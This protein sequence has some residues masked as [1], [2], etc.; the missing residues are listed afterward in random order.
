[1]Y[2]KKTKIQNLI[3]ST[4]LIFMIIILSVGGI[5][6]GILYFSELRY[7]PYKQKIVNISARSEPYTLPLTFCE[8]NIIK[9]YEIPC[10]RNTIPYNVT[11]SPL[12]DSSHIAVIEAVDKETFDD[13]I[14]DFIS[15]KSRVGT[16]KAYITEDCKYVP[17]EAGNEVDDK[18]L[19]EAVLCGF[20]DKNTYNIKDYYFPAEDPEAEHKEELVKK[21][22][23]SQITYTDGSVIK[24]ID[25]DPSY[26]AIT[27]SISLNKARIRESA[28][29]V[30]LKYDTVGKIELPFD[31]TLRGN[32][33]ISGGTWGTLSDSLAEMDAAEK[34]LTNLEVSE[35]RIPILKQSQ[36]SSLPTTYIEVDKENQKVFVYENGVRIME[37]DCVTGR[38][39][40]RETP[41]GIYFISERMID[42]TLKGPGYSSFVKRWM[43]L[44]NSGVG[45]HDASWRNKFGGDI[46][47]RDGS[48]GCINLPKDFAYKLYDWTKEHNKTCVIIF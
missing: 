24:A 31:S 16:K 38:Y 23:A 33:M 18:K 36:P 13:N 45:L 4:I 48:H 47:L 22:A 40:D 46:Y 39:P 42:K 6:W 7:D 8:G 17:P 30:S 10:I 9:T 14:A 44:T 1:M 11:I 37:S 21:L 29:D 34:L 35:N 3:L 15:L 2:V 12:Y 43:R 20:P 26:N 25:M 27:T 32:I 5:A 19:L 41:S 28:K